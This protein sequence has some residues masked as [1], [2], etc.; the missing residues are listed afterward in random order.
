MPRLSV[1][2]NN[3]TAEALKE[4]ADENGTTVTEIVR[5]AVSAY[6]FLED[7]IH[8]DTKLQLVNEKTR[9]RTNVAILR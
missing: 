4:L 9:E 2:I 5:R 3:E 8:G 7:E 6:K 1:N